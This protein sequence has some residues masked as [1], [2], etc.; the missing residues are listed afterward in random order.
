[1][2]SLLCQE[3][4]PPGP[5]TVK[6]VTN[7]RHRSAT[8]TRSHVIV[9]GMLTIPVAISGRGPHIKGMSK[10]TTIIGVRPRIV[11]Q[12]V[13]IGVRLVAAVV[14]KVVVVCAI[15]GCVVILGSVGKAQVGSTVGSASPPAAPRKVEGARPGVICTPLMA[16]ICVRAATVDGNVILH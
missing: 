2:R 4:R 10:V 1:M 14:G 7:I 6:V 13:A 3:R 9:P 8:R 15:R 11:G 16:S 12:L 5:R